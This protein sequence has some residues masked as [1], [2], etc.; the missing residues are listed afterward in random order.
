MHYFFKK[1]IKKSQSDNNAPIVQ[2]KETKKQSKGQKIK[3]NK[4]R[5]LSKDQKFH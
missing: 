1:Y 2:K 4:F 5:S 3:M